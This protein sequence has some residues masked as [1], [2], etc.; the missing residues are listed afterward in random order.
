MANAI[1]RKS[2]YFQVLAREFTLSSEDKVKLEILKD[3]YLLQV[4]TMMNQ[5][6]STKEQRGILTGVDILKKV[7][8]AIKTAESNRMFL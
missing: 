8:D 1:P 3:M 7:I 4:E 5:S 2:T 6:D